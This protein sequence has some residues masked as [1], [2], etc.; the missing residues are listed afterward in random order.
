MRCQ[1]VDDDIQCRMVA[2]RRVVVGMLAE[3][4][5]EV[6]RRLVVTDTKRL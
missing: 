3:M 1:H 2:T 5:A 4:E 6:A